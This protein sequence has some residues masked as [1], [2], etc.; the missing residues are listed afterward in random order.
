M[1]EEVLPFL[2]KDQFHLSEE[3][4]TPEDAKALWRQITEGKHPLTHEG[5]VIQPPTGTPL[6]AKK[7]EESDVHITDVFPGAGKYKGTAAGGF[8]YALEAG[9]PRVGEVGTGLTDDLRRQ[10]WKDRE[11]H[12]GRVA[13]IRSQEQHPSGAWRAPSLIALHE[14]YP[15]RTDDEA[16]NSM[17]R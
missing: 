9:G 2:P 10:M 15:T 12:V 5:V 1:I 3:A 11:E 13:R 8:G 16:D 14:D 4:T 7:L 17:R 6:K